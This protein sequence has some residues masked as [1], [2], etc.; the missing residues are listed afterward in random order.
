MEIIVFTILDRTVF[1]HRMLMFLSC[2]T[3]VLKTPTTRAVASGVKGG[4]NSRGP[5]KI[6][7]LYYIGPCSVNNSNILLV[8]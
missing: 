4:D 2:F 1:T 8:V 3:L 5:H 7:E 6:Q